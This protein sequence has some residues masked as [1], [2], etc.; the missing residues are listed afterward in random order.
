MFLVPMGEN[1]DD[2][3]RSNFYKSANVDDDFIDVS[4]SD[5]DEDSELLPVDLDLY[6]RITKQWL[7]FQE[8]A[9]FTIV[10]AGASTLFILFRSVNYFPLVIGLFGLSIAFVVIMF[11]FSWR[12]LKTLDNIRY[13]FCVVGIGFAAAVSGH[14]VIV[15]WISKN[16]QVIMGVSVGLVTIA[17]LAA[18][19]VVNDYFTRKKRRY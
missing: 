9:G 14:D 8:V 18:F 5:E 16:P 2:K 7:I 6:K 13:F 19:K 1:N 17:F 3:N 15:N 10:T 11:A 12:Q 4:S